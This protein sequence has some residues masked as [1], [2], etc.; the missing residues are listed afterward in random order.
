MTTATIDS[1]VLVRIIEKALDHEYALEQLAAAFTENGGS[2]LITAV[3][4]LPAGT[5]LRVRALGR[6]SKDEL[7][8]SLWVAYELSAQAENAR[9]LPELQKLITSKVTVERHNLYW[10][11]RCMLCGSYSRDPKTFTHA[12]DCT[13]R[14]RG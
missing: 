8:Q 5:C 9:Q 1:L 12:A 7:L 14:S 4:W 13:E 10:R 6:V 3:E 11:A 2:Q